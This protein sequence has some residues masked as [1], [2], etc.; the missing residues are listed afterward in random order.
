MSNNFNVI[1]GYDA[2]KKEVVKLTNMFNNYDEYSSKGIKLPKGLLFYG[3]PG[4]GKTLFSKVIAKEINRKFIELNFTQSNELDKHKQIKDVFE[5]AKRSAP[6]IVFIDEI[7]KLVP[8]VRPNRA[9]E[10]DS[11]RSNL[12]LL[13]QMLDGIN[14]Y[15]DV[16]V[17][18]TTNSLSELPTPLTRS[19]RIDKHIHL[20]LPCENS[21]LELINMYLNKVEYPHLLDNEKLVKLT[22]GLSGADIETIINEVFLEAIYEESTYVSTEDFIK[23]IERTR[24]KDLL[25]KP[26]PNHIDLVA[27][28]ELGH[29][30]ASLNS[31]L[32][33]REVS[34]YPNHNS[35]ASVRFARFNDFMTKVD[36]ENIVVGLLAGRAAEEVYFG[37]TYGGSYG[38]LTRAYR[39]IRES[40]TYGNYGFEYLALDDGNNLSDSMKDSINNKVKT[41]I[42]SL[43]QKALMIINDNKESI[44]ILKPYLKDKLVLSADDLSNYLKGELNVRSN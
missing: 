26:S 22:D 4:V 17:I 43:Y 39:M 18:A 36:I 32:Q 9:Y 24:N 31:K 12:H 44:D 2:E 35:L 16:M 27:T 40:L 23:Q 25:R 3:R 34:L 8:A 10:S 20:G 6:S 30:V 5:L 37:E 21:R 1:A 11:T 38:D 15:E 28:H 13:L 19:G 33:V 42:E 7:D 41:T 29:Y 14:T